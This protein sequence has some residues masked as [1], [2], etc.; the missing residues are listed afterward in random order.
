M[1]VVYT[2][3]TNRAPYVKSCN[4]KIGLNTFVITPK[5]YDEF[6]KLCLSTGL[7]KER[8]IK[9]TDAFIDFYNQVIYIRNDLHPNVIPSVVFG[10]I[11]QIIFYDS[12]IDDIQGTIDNVGL[13]VSALINTRLIQVLQDNKEA[14]IVYGIIRP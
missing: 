1:M 11:L 14:L 7:I 9:F 6:N 3:L 4:I 10:E 5:S 2:M 13:T 12:G 8:Q